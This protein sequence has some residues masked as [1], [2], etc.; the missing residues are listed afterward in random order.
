MNLC[1][2]DDQKSCAAC[3]GLYNIPIATRPA[4]RKNLKTRTL[5]FR[6]T[7]RSAKALEKFETFIRESGAMSCVDDAIHVCEFTGFLDEA[8]RV[9]GCMLHPRSPGNHGT[10]LRG[11][12]HYGSMACKTFF[13][14]AWDEL[15]PRCRSILLD[16]I[17]DWYLYGL[18][19]TDVDFVRSLF[20]LVEEGLGKQIEPGPLSSGP[21]LRIFKQM[22]S[23]KDSWP[24]G[25]LSSMRKSRYYFKGSCLPRGN[26][27]EAHFTRLLSTIRF[28]FDI[29]DAMDDADRFVGQMVEDFVSAYI[30]VSAST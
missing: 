24:F 15:D 26:T 20:G 22:L 16:T 23:W 14:P 25:G 1:R 12:C 27:Y 4:L 7:E 10:D 19:I 18:I 6:Q 9:V 30:E 17:D 2:P 11:L 13:C 29:E 8:F 3:C 5:L 28:T 21:A